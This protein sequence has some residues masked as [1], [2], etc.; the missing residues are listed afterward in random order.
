MLGTNFTS[1]RGL[2]S[3]IIEELFSQM[4]FTEKENNVEFLIKG[5]Y[6]EIYQEQIQDL[7]NPGVS[8]LQVREDLKR[9]I[10]L[11]GITE[12]VIS[13]TECALG[14]LKK[15]QTARHISSTSMNSESSRSHSVFTMVIE[16]KICN[17]GVSKITSSKFHF[18]DLAGS[19][20]QKQTLA[21]GER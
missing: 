21:S 8:N 14:L 18:V 13:S 4:A 6:Y 1:K 5:S 19:E 3:R 15:G 2:Q 9:G 10:F 20:R 16:S 12:E 7:L 11:E 17:N